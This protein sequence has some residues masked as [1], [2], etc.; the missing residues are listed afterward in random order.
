MHSGSLTRIRNVCFDARHVSAKY[1][2]GC[3][4][5]RSGRFFFSRV[6]K[7]TVPYRDTIHNRLIPECSRR[8]FP[9]PDT[10]CVAPDQ[11]KT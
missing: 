7:L 9:V 2:V 4:I 10:V 3:F 11:Q 1:L 8:I 6:A 5:A